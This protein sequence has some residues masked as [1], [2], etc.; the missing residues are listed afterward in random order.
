MGLRLISDHEWDRQMDDLRQFKETLSCM[1]EELQFLNKKTDLIMDQNAAIGSA[2]DNLTN[3]V[4][5][6]VTELKAIAGG[7]APGM[8]DDQAQAIVDRIN[9]VATNLSA[10]EKPATATPPVGGDQTGS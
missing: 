7:V 5:E 10:V 6:G 2:L 8:T 4:N 3:V 1:R 9:G